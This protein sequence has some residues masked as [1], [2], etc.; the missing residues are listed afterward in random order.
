M[1]S[2][3]REELQRAMNRRE[4]VLVDVLSV[5]QFRKSHLPGAIN[6]PADRI[7]ELAPQL[8]P[9]RSARIVTYCLNFTGRVSDQVARSLIDMGYRNVR[10][11]DEGKQD[12]MNAGLPLEGEAPNEPIVGFRPSATE[13]EARQKLRAAS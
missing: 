11:Y 4:V 5:E 8:L 3:T 12:W 13:L 6:I 7:A 9:D 10:N 2:I 1:Q